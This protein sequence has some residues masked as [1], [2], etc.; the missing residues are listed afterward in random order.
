M[1]IRFLRGRCWRAWRVML[2]FDAGES[3]G[4]CIEVWS[5]GLVK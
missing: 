1:S 2:E 5:S 4:W 3:V